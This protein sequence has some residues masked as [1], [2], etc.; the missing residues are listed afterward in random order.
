MCIRDSRKDYQLPSN[1]MAA[2]KLVVPDSLKNQYKPFDFSKKSSEPLK[3]AQKK[4][5]INKQKKEVD[6]S[7]LKIKDIVKNSNRMDSEFFNP[8]N[9]TLDLRLNNSILYEQITGNQKDRMEKRYGESS[10]RWLNSFYK[11]LN[12]TSKVE[13]YAEIKKS[14]SK[15]IQ[16]SSISTANVPV[17]YTHLD[18]YKRQIS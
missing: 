13:T 16:E 14:I 15:A 12:Q 5:H 4:S 1:L 6:E 18:V 3:Q 7:R 8:S 9:Q 10:K 17:S 2:R 11:L